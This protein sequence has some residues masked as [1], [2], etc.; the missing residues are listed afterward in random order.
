MLFEYYEQQTRNRKDSIK[1]I[2]S[3]KESGDLHS[4][5]IKA[6]VSIIARTYFTVGGF[7]FE[8]I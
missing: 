7:L 6:D 3:T 1:G 8:L 2:T 5:L 4:H